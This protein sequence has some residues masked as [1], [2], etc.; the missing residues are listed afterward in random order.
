MIIPL[1]W[2]ARLCSRYHLLVTTATARL[3][4]PR[5]L[6]QAPGLG[7]EPELKLAGE[8]IPGH[9][10]ED[11]TWIWTS[12]AESLIIKQN[13]SFLSSRRSAFLLCTVRPSA[14]W[15]SLLVSITVDSV[16]T[17]YNLWFNCISHPHIII[18]ILLVQFIIIGLIRCQL[19]MVHI[20]T[21]CKKRFHQNFLINFLINYVLL[22]L[23]MKCGFFSG[24]TGT[25]QILTPSIIDPS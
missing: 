24:T 12:L 8:D 21:F 5:F 13:G 7:A 22:K 3:L 17:Q 25:W 20:F 11:I 10:T 14:G 1:Y 15:H 16:I 18:V 23:P 2:P 9:N 19:C 6:W 4:R